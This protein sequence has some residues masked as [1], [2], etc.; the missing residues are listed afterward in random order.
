MVRGRPLTRSV[1]FAYP[2]DLQAKTGGY[3]YDRQIISQLQKLGWQV[4]PVPLGSG[5][6]FPDDET[7]RQAEEAL[8]ALGKDALVI[9]DGL[10]YGTFGP[11][12][13]RLAAKLNLIA[14]VHHPLASEGNMSAHQQ[15]SLMKSE[16]E[17]LAHAKTILVTS[18]ATRQQLV[19]DYDVPV[20]RIVVAIPGTERG[21]RAKRSSEIPQI[22]SVGSLIP[23][24]GHDVLIGALAKIA[25]L[26]WECRIIGTRTMDID[27]DAAIQKQII[28]KE[29]TDRIIL[30]GQVDDTR[31]ELAHADIFALASRYEGY[32]M[33]FAEALSHGLPIIACHAGSVPE[34]V[35]SDAGIL[36]PADDPD[37]FADALR[38]VLKDKELSDQMA[39]AAFGHGKTLPEWAGTAKLIAAALIKATDE[40]I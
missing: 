20:D 22:L 15:I 3:G 9:V 28:D 39:E 30:A 7:L 19:S 25:D 38:L 2:G 36:V 6:P 40:R 27:Y 21:I 17:A 4:N 12:A 1:H 33:V 29:L 11:I 37:A 16:R 18:S 35:P 31:S 14:L 34:V 5:F 26:A 13:S 23:R 8:C 32:G 10:A 24:K